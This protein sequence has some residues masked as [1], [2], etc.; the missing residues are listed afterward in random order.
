MVMSSPHG[1]QSSVLSND[2]GLVNNCPVLQLCN[3]VWNPDN[4]GFILDLSVDLRIVMFYL[5]PI[6]GSSRH[7]AAFISTLKPLDVE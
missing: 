1:Q 3:E 6:H 2:F 7:G 5:V 4:L